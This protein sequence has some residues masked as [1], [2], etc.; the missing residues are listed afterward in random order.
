LVV[1]SAVP[2]QFRHRPSKKP[3]LLGAG[4]D[5]A[6]AAALGAIRT[7]GSSAGLRH[8]EGPLPTLAMVVAFAAPGV[9]AL[10][11]VAI[12]RPVLF[13]AAGFACMPLI[14]VSI[15]AFPMVIA[16]VVLIVAYSQ[17]SAVTPSPRLFGGL[18]LGGFFVPILVGLWILITRTA[19]FTYRY[20]GG[21]EGGDYFTPGHAALCIGLVVADV[22]IVTSLAWRLPPISK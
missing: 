22:L 9:V 12:D 7:A 11:G 19:Q 17:A 2:P 14:F 3:A 6:L 5:L 16:G 13:G 15:V 1:T 18:I 20:A 8:V 10:I 4:L 21:S